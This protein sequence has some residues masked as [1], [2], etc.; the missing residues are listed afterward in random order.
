MVGQ[1]HL[2]HEVV[3]EVVCN[4]IA[5]AKVP[6][7]VSLSGGY[8]NGYSGLCPTYTYLY[9]LLISGVIVVP[10]LICKASFE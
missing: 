2:Q 10:E 6:G 5:V 1:V 3:V 8:I 9:S 4:I 7:T